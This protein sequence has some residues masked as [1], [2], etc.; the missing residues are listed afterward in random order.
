MFIKHVLKSAF[1]LATLSHSVQAEWY[2]VTGKS[3][4]LESV[5][6]AR[7]RALEDALFQVLEFSGADIGTI[8]SLRPHLAE[9]KDRYVFQGN[10]VNQ[11]N[12]IKAE[13]KNKA[14]NITVRIDVSPAAN[15]CHNTQYKKGFLLSNFTIRSPQEGSL[16]GIFNLGQDFSYLLER[17]IK[18]QSQSFVSS[19]ISPYNIST[20]DPNTTSII[21]QDS[22]AKFILTGEIADISA[23]LRGSQ[24]NRQLSVN[25]NVLEGD[26]GEVIY[27]NAYRDIAEWPF[28]KNSRVDTKSA[29]FWTSPYGE[30]VM[31]LGRNI[32]IDIEEN[33]SCRAST[34]E[35]IVLNGQNGQINAGRIHGVRNGDTLNLWHNASFIDQFGNYHNQL[36]KSAISLTI[37][38]V[39]DNAAEFSV[40][41]LELR[42]SIQIGDIA[43]KN[44]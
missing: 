11:I 21:A 34:P 18:T 35:V 14:V 41:P 24:T 19:G 7:A 16:G 1:L 39:Y 44:L 30:M 37:T 27:E 31:R 25:I 10:E 28:E 12:V 8:V 22:G 6:D 26:S 38:R 32:L 5:N 20:A 33:L 40:T 4:I 36:K 29:R 13:R 9:N 23:T 43:T 3:S 15:D 42:N 2:E 17:L